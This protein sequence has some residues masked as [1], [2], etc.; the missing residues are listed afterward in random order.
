[1]R[2]ISFIIL[3]NSNS[4][5]LWQIKPI[6]F[7]ELRFHED[8]KESYLKKVIA[9]HLKQLSF[10]NAYVIILHQEEDE[11]GILVFDENGVRLI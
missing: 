8:W 10:Q 11:S 1:M 2:K 3:Y 4:S 7:S 5:P 9:E 6:K